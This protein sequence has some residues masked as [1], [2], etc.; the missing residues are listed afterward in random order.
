MILLILLKD[1]LIKL[2][3]L[4][5]WWS[6]YEAETALM[7]AAKSVSSEDLKLNNIKRFNDITIFKGIFE[8]DEQGNAEVDVKIPNYFGIKSLCCCS[9]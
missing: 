6:D 1:I 9:S 5:N 3:I 8:S 7:A 4:K 2:E